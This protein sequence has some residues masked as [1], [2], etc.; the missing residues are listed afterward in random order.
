MELYVKLNIPYVSSKNKT[1]ITE[2]KYD[3]WDAPVLKSKSHIVNFRCLS[4]CC[5]FSFFLFYVTVMWLHLV[6]VR[7]GQKWTAA[8]LCGVTWVTSSFWG[9][10]LLNRSLCVLRVCV[11]VCIHR[12]RYVSLCALPLLIGVCVFSKK[13]RRG[14]SRLKHCHSSPDR[15]FKSSSLESRWVYGKEKQCGWPRTCNLPI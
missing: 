2:E 12:W 9:E 6:P 7:Q 5:F 14:P 10:T 4:S 13:A 11:C 1:K 3:L 15:Q 8:D